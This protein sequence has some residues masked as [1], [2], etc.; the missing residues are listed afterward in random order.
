MGEVDVD[1]HDEGEHVDP[2]T[3]S[4]N[5]IAKEILE[6]RNRRSGDSKGNFLTKKENFVLAAGVIY[7]IL[8]VLLLV[9]MT[10][11][12]F[13]NSTAIDHSASKTFLDIGG[14]CEEITDEPWILIFPNE[15]A[16]KFSLYGYNLPSGYGVG[17]FTINEIHEGSQGVNSWTNSTTKF[18]PP[19]GEADAGK[20]YFSA[21][22]EE[23]DEGHYNLN[24]TVTVYNQTD[25]ANASIVEGGDE[26]YKMVEFDLDIS[27]QTFAFLP[28]V[29]SEQKHQVRL[30]ETGAR[31]CWGVQD[32]GNWGYVLIG[33]ELGGGRE[34]AML[35]GGAAGIPA[36]WMAF[37]SLSLSAISLLII[38]PLMYKVYHQDSDDILS[39]N[40]IS[41]LVEDSIVKTAKRLNIEIDWELYK[42]EPRDLSI[43]IMMPYKNTESTLS[44]SKDVRAEVLREVL[45]EFA[46][47]RVF[48]PVQLT[49]RT[50]G[51]NQAIDF[52][53][54]VGVGTSAEIEDESEQN[55]TD[56]F[57]ELHTL[58]RV[59]D[60]V[61]ESLELFFARR[62]ELNMEAAVVTSDDRVIF[63]SVIYRPTQRFAF[64]R[65]KKTRDE[66]QTE[67]H[68]FIADR[69]ADL[70]GSQELI[71][72]GRNQVSTLSERAGAG[73]VERDVKNDE[74]I[75]AVAKQDGFG[76]KMLQT[77]LLG[78]TLSTV[79]YMANEKREM[80][81]K[82]G[83]WGL[84][85]FVWI[86]FMASGVLV[87]AM[88]GLL[89]RMNF[90]RVLSAT[91]IGGSIASIT[92][93]YTAEGIVKFM[94]QYKLEAVIPL[95]IV[96][97]VGA[98]FLHIR[99]TKMR[100]Q[101]ELFEDTLLDN[102][103]ANIQAKYGE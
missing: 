92:W 58:S 13:G 4:R 80:I 48:K 62:P 47:F 77:K 93:A 72:K 86:P 69:N 83:F 11:G 67:L 27:K 99:S 53:S 2:E 17:T 85:V 56:F 44:D 95:I 90:T 76:G 16:R 89:S 5:K 81:N 26:I 96:V 64:F 32:L 66:V 59:E 41:H 35:A 22:F 31:S 21:S 12:T 91:I 74:R 6:I 60:E 84:I 39:R 98:A 73:R 102:F 75:V 10:S 78:D 19:T 25:I 52:E 38:Y 51:V 9:G 68:R 28:F 101:T 100:R 88:L 63:V 82:W 49:V 46:I 65:F 14:E 97:F 42:I 71:V 55:Y 70:L 1:S 54:G 29:D 36:W 45:E 94:H 33:A 40:H 34:T 30:T 3:K 57:S 18:I 79:E 61:R 23:L 15:D 8:Y 87:G 37:S 43:D 20:M 7:T 24:Y 50:I 103:H